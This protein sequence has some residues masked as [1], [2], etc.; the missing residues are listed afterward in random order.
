M[1]VAEVL[2][3]AGSESV[4][5]ARRKPQLQD[6]AKIINERYGRK[7]DTISADLGKVDDF[8]DIVEMA[9]SRFG[10]LDVLINNAG[11]NIRKPF[12]EVEPEAFDRVISVPLRSA[13]FMVKAAARHM[14]KAGGGKIINMALLSS[15]IAVPNISPAARPR[16]ESLL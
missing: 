10:P 2:A 14:A 15:K 4:L 16:A 9:L 13:C 8:G 7:V 11:S 3:D 12:L 6:A 1:A 5:V